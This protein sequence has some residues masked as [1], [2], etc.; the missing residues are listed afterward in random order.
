ML[1]IVVPVGTHGTSYG[2]VKG[3]L[4]VGIKDTFDFL[5][6]AD[7]GVI[8]EMTNSRDGVE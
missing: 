6:K 1:K 5:T 2:K 4:R 3:K 8:G 7:L